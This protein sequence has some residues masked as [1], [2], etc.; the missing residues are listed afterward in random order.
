MTVNLPLVL[1]LGIAAWLAV[2]FLRIRPWAVLALVL[3]GFFLAH[4]FLAPAI[5][6]GTQTG[7]QIVNTHH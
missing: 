2:K 4:T 3:F 6:S 5:N 1:L 7:V